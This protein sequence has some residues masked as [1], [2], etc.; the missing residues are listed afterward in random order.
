M[1]AHAVGADVEDQRLDGVGE[2][3]RHGVGHGKDQVDADGAGGV[4]LEV[5]VK[6]GLLVVVLAKGADHANAG[7]GLA[8]AHVHA[9]DEALHDKEDR[10]RFGDR[11]GADQQADHRDGEN[12]VAHRG[13]QREGEDKGDDAGQGHRAHHDEAHEQRLLDHVGVRHRAGD[14]RAGAKAVEVGTA[15]GQRAAIDSHAHVAAH[16]GGEF[17][18]H[19]VAHDAAAR[20]QKRRHQ[21]DGA[22]APDGVHALARGHGVEQGRQ[23]GGDKEHAHDV[24]AQ[25]DQGD[26]HQDLVGAHEL[27]EQ[28]EGRAHRVVALR[29]VVN[30]SGQQFTRHRE[31]LLPGFEARSGSRRRTSRP[32]AGTRPARRRPRSRRRGARRGWRG[33]SSRRR[34]RGRQL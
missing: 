7:D 31:G 2:E 23:L 18:R 33:R 3:K 34:R 30:G 25:R 22:V 27:P 12:R 5:V 26:K 16:V 17:G 4:G 13:V 14:H 8:Q 11:K 9:V 21:H 20:A 28:R 6:A 19:A 10:G 15:K 29:I 1:D 24:A 32:G